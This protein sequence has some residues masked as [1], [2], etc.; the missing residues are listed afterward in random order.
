L[1]RTRAVKLII[2]KYNLLRRGLRVLHL[3]P[4]KGLGAYIRS[5]VGERWLGKTEQGG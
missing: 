1:E 3:A 2:D 5:I 4:E